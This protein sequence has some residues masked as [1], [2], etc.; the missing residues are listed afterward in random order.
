MDLRAQR[1]ALWVI[2]VD[3][4]LEQFPH[5]AAAVHDLNARGDL[6]YLEVRDWL[7]GHEPYASP[8]GHIWGTPAH[9]LI[10]EHL[11]AEAATALADSSSAPKS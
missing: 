5:I 7:R 2:S 6:R 4:Q 8:E 10:G 11:A 9:A 1:R 3:G